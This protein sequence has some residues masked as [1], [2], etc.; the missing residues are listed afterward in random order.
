M[1]PRSRADL[2][3][4]WKSE[5]TISSSRSDAC[6]DSASGRFNPGRL[7]IPALPLGPGFRFGEDR[8]GGSGRDKLRP[9]LI[10]TRQEVIGLLSTV[11]VAPI[12]SAIRG[13]PSEV[14]VG[15]EEGLKGPSVV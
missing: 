6:E 10:L 1:Q 12:T 2:A 7:Q 15:V 9:V 13:A 14:S 3:T 5:R 8:E 4:A 11:M